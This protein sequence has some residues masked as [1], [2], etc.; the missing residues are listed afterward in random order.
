MLN[1]NWDTRINP[2]GVK[3]FII[4]YCDVTVILSV[5]HSSI[6]ANIESCENVIVPYLIISNK[7]LCIKGALW[8][9]LI[10][11]DSIYLRDIY[12]RIGDIYVSSF[13]GHHYL[14]SKLKDARVECD[15]FKWWV[16][17]EKQ[18]VLRGILESRLKESNE[19]S[20]NVT[21][22]N[23][24]FSFIAR[25]NRSSQHSL[26][27]GSCVVIKIRLCLSLRLE[28][29]IETGSGS[30]VPFMMNYDICKIRSDINIWVIRVRSILNRFKLGSLRLT[31]S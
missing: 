14:L 8:Q 9:T 12:E 28:C 15:P 18:S 17:W 20:G 13:L 11:R 4:C 7:S 1:I 22:I 19:L 24:K 10:Y 6:A 26:V 30:I 3:E 21:I 27:D 16:V 23:D 5:D 31:Q 25:K 2:S 29:R